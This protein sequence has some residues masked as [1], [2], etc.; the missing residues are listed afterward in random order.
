MLTITNNKK[1]FSKPNETAE[2]TQVIR[3]DYI[4]TV[5]RDLL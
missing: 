5:L 2:K 3:K 4:N 1:T